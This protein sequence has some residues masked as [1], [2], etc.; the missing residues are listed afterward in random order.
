MNKQ[1]FCCFELGTCWLLCC[2][3]ISNSHLILW[4]DPAGRRRTRDQLLAAWRPWLRASISGPDRTYRISAPLTLKC[5]LP[6]LLFLSR[7]ASSLTSAQWR[8]LFVSWCHGVAMAHNKHR[9]CTGQNLVRAATHSKQ[10]VN[11][12]SHID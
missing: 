12:E 7:G 8:R 2:E 5:Q 1:P 9:R 10:P 3:V 4:S 11:Q 6:K